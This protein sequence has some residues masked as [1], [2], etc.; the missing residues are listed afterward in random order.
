MGFLLGSLSHHFATKQRHRVIFFATTARCLYIELTVLLP[1]S[2]SSG[3]LPVLAAE[4][5]DL[6]EK[7]CVPS[8]SMLFDPHTGLKKGAK[9]GS[10]EARTAALTVGFHPG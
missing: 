5:E 3:T 7:P 1:V 4:R 2:K 9:T 8:F 10:P 6:R